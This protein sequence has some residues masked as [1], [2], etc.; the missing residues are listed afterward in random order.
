MECR[1]CPQ[2]FHFDNIP[3]MRESGQKVGRRPFGERWRVHLI[4]AALALGWSVLYLDRSILFPLL[5][6]IAD[7]FGLTDAQSGAISSVYFITYVFM[8][9]PS[10]VLGDRFGLKRVLVVMYLIIGLGLFFIGLFSASFLLLLLFIGIQGFG[11]GAY[12]AGSYGITISSVPPRWRGTSSSVV[13]SGMALGSALGLGMAGLLYSV[14]ESWRAPYLFM[15]AP[16]LLMAALIGF[17]IRGVP[18]APKVEGGIAFLFRNR[19][20]IPLCVTNFCALYAYMV[21]FT[22]GPS[23][24]VNQHGMSITGAGLFTSAVAGASLVGAL[25]WGRLSDKLGRKGLTLAMLSG[26]AV[27]LSVAAGVD[28]TP[29]IL[30]AFVAYGFLGALAWNP[31]IVAWAGDHTFA[32]GRVGMGTVMGV[33]NTV[34]ISSAFIAP[35]V[36]G[37]ISDRTDSLEMAFFLATAVQLVG[38]VAALTAREKP[39]HAECASAPGGGA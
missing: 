8:Q 9:I 1:G 24:L 15:L 5:P 4:V 19:D 20:F 38:V 12:Y 18:R 2:D 16:T 21:I 25:T 39:A 29:A 6:V 3:S 7:D 33:M 34:G 13:T 30:G 28:S 35:V 22:W 17:A 14:S 10:G 37:W 36:S 23:F 27:M 11:A 31:I 26:S 32:T